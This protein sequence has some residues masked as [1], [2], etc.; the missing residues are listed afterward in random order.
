MEKNSPPPVS[1]ASAEGPSP[2]SSRAGVPKTLKPELEH[3]GS[4]WKHPYMLYIVLTVILF[5]LLLVIGWLA[6]SS[7]WIPSRGAV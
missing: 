2:S 7:G 4:I 5:I 6:Y 3:E 1:N